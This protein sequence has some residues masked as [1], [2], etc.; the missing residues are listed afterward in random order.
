MTDTNYEHYLTLEWE[1]FVQDQT[2][3]QASL[4][5][6]QGRQISRVLDIGCG[7][8]QNS[9]PLQWLVHSALVWMYRP[10]SA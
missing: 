4:L 3:A 6:V 1:M 7:A 5:A 2:R 9:S 10:T 8:G